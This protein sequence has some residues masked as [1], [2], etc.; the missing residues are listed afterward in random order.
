MTAR[1]AQAI[2]ELLALTSPPPSPAALADAQDHAV[3]LYQHGLPATVVVNTAVARIASTVEQ[4]AAALQFA[5][6]VIRRRGERRL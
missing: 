4:R 1:T 2:A 5:A 6:G 3:M